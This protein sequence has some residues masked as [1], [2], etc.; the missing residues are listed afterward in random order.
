MTLFL[1]DSI[2]QGYLFS[3]RD[4]RNLVIPLIL[5]QL[6]GVTVGM[7]DSIMVSYAGEAAVSGVSLVDSIFI[8]IQQMFAALAAGGAVVAGQYLGMDNKQKACRSVN[9]LLIVTALAGLAVTLF[10]YASR[11]FLLDS[12]FGKITPAVRSSADVYLL[13][14]S[15]SVP[16]MTSFL[17]AFAVFR[18]QGDSK[19]SLRIS[20]VMNVINLFGNALL[21]YGFK[22]GTAGVAIPTLVSRMAGAVICLRY[23]LR[24]HRTL[25]ISLPFRFVIERKTLYNI[26]YIGV[27]NGFESFMFN[28]GKIILLSLVAEFGTASIAANAI[29]NNFG[30][31]QVLPGLALSLA[32]VT[33]VSRCAG[34]AD[35]EQ[36][37][38]YT[39]RLMKMSTVYCSLATLLVF[40]LSW[41]VLKIYNV[42]AEANKLA[43]IITAIHGTG[44]FFTYTPS[45]VLPN[46]LR[47]ANDV[48]YCLI[49]SSVS[50]WLARVGGSYVLARWFGMGVI[51][52]WLAMQLDWIFRS[53]CFIR[54]FKG[55]EWHSIRL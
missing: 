9:Q 3:K 18:A 6:L 39:K 10:L 28:F 32:M 50:M 37:R 15:A 33:V 30:L 25:H 5:E 1:E 49:I 35:I 52:V 51:G 55:D 14:T 21:V 42:S 17:T 38:F 7:L 44:T 19:L 31:Y 45:F 48:K 23:L 13:I 27:P 11:S 46:A 22:M 54:R 12:V 41:P 29:G 36:A 47:S 43:L 16:F 40:A 20:V 4:I 24:Q 2:P 53:V 8:L 26:L 34:A